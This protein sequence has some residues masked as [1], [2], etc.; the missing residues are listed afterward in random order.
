MNRSLYENYS[1]QLQNKSPVSKTY[2][3]IH[4]VQITSH[5]HFLHNYEHERGCWVIEHDLTGYDSSIHDKLSH[6]LME[7]SGTF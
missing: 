7:S 2:Q 3:A 5:H 6:I 4:I 1:D